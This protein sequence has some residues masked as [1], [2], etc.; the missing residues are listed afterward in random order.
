MNTITYSLHHLKVGFGIVVRIFIG[1]VFIISAV[2]KIFSSSTA[3]NFIEH[4]ISLSVTSAYWSVVVL[5][6]ME[7]V[8]GVFL[9]L[10]RYVVATSFLS[11]C[12]FLFA[13]VIGILFIDQSIPCGCFGDLVDSRTDEVF[14]FKLSTSPAQSNHLEQAHAI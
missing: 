2:T 3:V 12:F 5:S 1:S 4:I 9:V 13:T 10:N 8:I 14:L 6:V 7:F 11:S